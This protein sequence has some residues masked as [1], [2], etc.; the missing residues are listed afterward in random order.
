MR[1]DLIL[2][3]LSIFLIGVLFVSFRTKSK[4]GLTPFELFL[5]SALIITLMSSVLYMVT[6]NENFAETRNTQRS[7]DVF[8]IVYAVNQFYADHDAEEDAVDFIPE[9]PRMFEIGIGEGRVDL[10]TILIDDYVL[11]LPW[12]PN[13]GTFA[14]T[15]YFIC[16]EEERF[17]VS[18]PGA[19][20]QRVIQIKL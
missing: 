11:S 20:N 16:R 10:A 18:A 3:G 2:I 15:N 17:V 12:D 5:T 4:P 13:G 9:C 1:T 8:Q 19:E 6:T 7:N 14:A